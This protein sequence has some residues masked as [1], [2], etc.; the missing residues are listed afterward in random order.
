MEGDKNYHLPTKNG[1]KGNMKVNGVD[2]L[3]KSTSSITSSKL[4][5]WR[6]N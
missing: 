4:D 3:G 1:E 5:K 6:I 2:F